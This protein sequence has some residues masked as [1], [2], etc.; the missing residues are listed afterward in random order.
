M[1]IY[2][3]SRSYMTQ[4]PTKSLDCWQR[5]SWQVNY[6]DYKC[7]PTSYNQV[8]KIVNVVCQ[9]CVKPNMKKLGYTVT[10]QHTN[11]DQTLGYDRYVSN[12]L[13]VDG[14]GV[15]E[16]EWYLVTIV[17]NIPTHCL[18]GC[19]QLQEITKKLF[20]GCHVECGPR[21]GQ[22]CI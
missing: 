5:R 4:K 2:F 16:L 14:G 15:G 18:I 21:F 11:R 6:V 19:I 17:N 9:K 7:I 13:L 1:S 8:I 10:T 22:L 3:A 12:L 20:V